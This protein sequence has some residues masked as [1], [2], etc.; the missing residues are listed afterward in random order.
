MASM[1]QAVSDA[2]RKLEE[3]AQKIEQVLPK[4]EA[5]VAGDPGATTQA[6][7]L[8]HASTTV[9]KGI[10]AIAVCEKGWAN[11]DGNAANGC[12]APVR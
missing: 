8:P 4:L 2:A 11:A 5:L 3:V 12:E 6:C 1:V 7:T 10:C 9:V